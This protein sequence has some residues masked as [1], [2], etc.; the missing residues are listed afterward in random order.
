VSTTTTLRDDLQRTLSPLGDREI[1]TALARLD[2]ATIVKMAYRLLWL[3]HRLGLRPEA[4]QI[5][6]ATDAYDLEQA[7]DDNAG[8]PSRDWRELDAEL[9][10]DLPPEE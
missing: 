1:G 9:F 2:D 4:E 6:D 7:V 5:E 10:G 8:K 3:Y